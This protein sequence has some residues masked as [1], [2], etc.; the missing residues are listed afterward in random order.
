MS[1]S[2][3][4]SHSEEA[5]PV[6]NIKN[7]ARQTAAQVRDAATEAFQDI[8]ARGEAVAGDIREKADDLKQQLEVYV[9]NNPTKSVLMAAGA[10]FVM[11]LLI[12][13]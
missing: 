4:N 8:R 3:N 13:R 9:R 10:G 12:R 2:P 7:Q 6:N 1:D 5:D 11:G